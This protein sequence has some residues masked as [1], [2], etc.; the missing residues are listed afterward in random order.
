MV[1]DVF[2]FDMF[3][4]VLVPQDVR[5]CNIPALHLYLI[6]LSWIDQTFSFDVN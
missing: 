3:L 5:G 4:G 1:S 6:H 2:L